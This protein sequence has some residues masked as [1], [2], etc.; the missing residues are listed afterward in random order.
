MKKYFAD[1]GLNTNGNKLE[2]LENDWVWV[3]SVS[4]S[5]EEEAMIEFLEGGELQSYLRKN[6]TVE[7]CVN[8]ET[9]S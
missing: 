2:H 4:V 6:H 8:E 7:I 3:R 1:E 5:E 9:Q